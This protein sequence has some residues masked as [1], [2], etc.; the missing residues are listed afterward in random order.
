[1]SSRL[2]QAHI[3]GQKRLRDGTRSALRGIWQDLPAYD[4]PNLGQWLSEA[5]PVVEAAQRQ[6][7]ALTNAYLAASLERQPLG[8]DTRELVGAAVRNGT[9]PATVYER[10]FVTVWTAL[11]NQTP[12]EQ[13]VADGLARAQGMASFD[14]QGSMRATAGA[15]QAADSSI[16]GYQR[17]ADAGACPFCVEVD[18]AYVKNASAMALHNHCGCGLEPLT[19]PH[20]LAAKLPSGVAVHQHGEMGA[21]LTAP[22]Q[23]FTSEAELAHAH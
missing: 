18:G 13:A 2:V 11:G 4:R 15:V 6:S 22:G 7:V 16:Y 23:H 12:W 14:V 17:V 9:P 20:P 21:V 10:P 5:L 3:L 19:S 8:L 1:M